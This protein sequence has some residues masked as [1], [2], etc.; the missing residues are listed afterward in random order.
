MGRS[1]FARATP[2]CAR[3][4]THCLTTTARSGRD[5]SMPRSTPLGLRARWRGQEYDAGFTATGDVLLLADAE[6]P[7]TREFLPAAAGRVAAIVSGNEIEAV[8]EVRTLTTWRRSRSP[9]H[10]RP[11]TRARNTRAERLHG[12]GA[13]AEFRRPGVFRGALPRSAVPELYQERR[14][15]ERASA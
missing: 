10:H 5:S 14:P 2:P 15:Y 12:R 7:G 1:T 4:S 8:H 13:W 11:N 3:T 9:C 6:S